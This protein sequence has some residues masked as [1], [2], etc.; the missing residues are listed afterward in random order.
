MSEAKPPADAAKKKSKLPLIIGLVVGVVV[1]IGG[2]AVAVM[3]FVKGSQPPA[4]AAEPAAEHEAAPAK[5]EGDAKGGHGEAPKGGHEP[6]K[7]GGGHASGG[8]AKGGDVVSAEIPPVV[9]DLS[10]THGDRTR[11]L[12]VGLVAELADGSNIDDFK[13]L[14]PR[15]REAALSY[16]RT[17]TYE[18]VSDPSR[19]LE[20]KQELSQRVTEAI[21][22]ERVSRILLVDFVSQ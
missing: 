11:H 18:E 9:V 20:I 6:A 5:K 3:L 8:H 15:A 10:S 2:T 14:L 16:L 7:K 1:L 21:G 17:L 13:P 22:Q 12:K 4:A 19:F